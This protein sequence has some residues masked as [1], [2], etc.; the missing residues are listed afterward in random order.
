MSQ[1]A[2]ESSIEDDEI[3]D[4]HRGPVTCVAGIPGGTTAVSSAYDGAVAYVDLDSNSIELLG[5]HD[6]L[7]NRICVD[8]TGARAASASSDFTI[9]IWDLE[10]RSLVRRLR[11]HS[12]D[13]EDFIFVGE[14]TG[15]SVSR[16]CR[17][18]VWNLD[19]GAIVR[20]I[21]GHEKDV[22]SVVHH[23][24]KIF[25]SGDDMTLRVW[26]LQT[27]ELQRMWG[28]FDTETDSC[29]ID[30]I[31][32]RAVLGCD[33]GVIRIFDLESGEAV[34]EID[35]HASG[36]KKV[37]T[38]PVT[39]D[40]FSAAYDQKI[41]VW[42]A[43]DFSLKVALEARPSMWERSFNWSPDGSRLL[44][45]TFDGTILEWDSHSGRFLSEIGDADGNA[46]LNDVSA[47]DRGDIVVVSDDGFVRLGRLT[48]DEATVVSEHE[49]AGG[50]VLANAVTL[51]DV[52]SRVLVGAHNQTLL[53]LDRDGPS[54]TGEQE[55]TLGEG[56]INCVRVAHHPGLEGEAFVACYSGTIVRLSP[57]GT[58]HSRIRVH[59]GAV[60]ALR[61]HPKQEIGVSCSAD[62]ALLSWD[63]AGQLLK[64]YPG[65]MAIVDDVDISPS[66]ERIASVSRDF[67]LKVYGLESGRLLHSIALG[68]RSPKGLLFL[69]EDTVIVTNDWG[70][71]IRA[72]LD[73]GRVTR[74][75]I[76]KNGISAVARSGEHLVA[77][78]YDGA[79]YLVDSEDLSVVNTLRCMTQRLQASALIP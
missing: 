32:N 24:G 77:V 49:P 57:D 61:L 34:A 17:I 72:E 58:I 73:S 5:Y 41:L 8:D 11:G 55:I 3:F 53:L 68:R 59:E 74:R 14:S 7:V 35:A 18:L 50:R 2:P 26:D 28:P 63:F 6:H 38:S 76:A 25:T 1:S 56:P 42:D 71:L 62:G 75:A 51:D 19:T 4:R 44:A 69:E 31:H 52:G 10:N 36:I 27:G 48:P 39:G 43:D 67:T 22:L 37:A 64:R 33:D 70:E 60:K 46:C 79:A 16:D 21:E 20:T 30:S 13:V 78:S 29:A 47:N 54:F 23:E 40:I 45:G 66:G 65:H 15:V 12:D 9:A